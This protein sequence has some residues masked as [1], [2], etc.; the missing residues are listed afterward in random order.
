MKHSLI[1]LQEVLDVVSGADGHHACWDAVA[2]ALRL[3][4]I[5]GVVEAQKQIVG[6]KPENPLA[7]I[8]D[9]LHTLH[10]VDQHG[11]KSKVG[12]VR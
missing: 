11:F 3:E 7:R 1:S 5:N 9:A 8:Y 10:F 2:E 12:D 4:V 6:V